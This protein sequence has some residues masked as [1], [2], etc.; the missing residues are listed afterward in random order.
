MIKDLYNKVHD[1]FYNLNEDFLKDLEQY[2][3]DT[4]KDMI[5]AGDLFNEYTL[6]TLIKKHCDKFSN[7]I[8]L[9]NYVDDLKENNSISCMEEFY[10]L[11]DYMLYDID[12]WEVKDYGQK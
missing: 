5:E 3:I 1:L 8:P 4:S 12:I 7:D 6:E 11:I 10:E 2:T 9:M